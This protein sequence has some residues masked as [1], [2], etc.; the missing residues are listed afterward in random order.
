MT[1]EELQTYGLSNQP[2]K[3]LRPANDAELAIIK[4][5]IS[6]SDEA[7]KVLALP[8]NSDALA[9]TRF[10]GDNLRSKP[11]SMA[12]PRP[13]ANEVRDFGTAGFRGAG[14]FLTDTI[15][16]GANLVSPLFSD[17]Q[18]ES[19]GF[20]RLKEIQRE[21][22]AGYAP[23]EE[24]YP[25]ATTVGESLVPAML[26]GYKARELAAV[27]GL[28]GA[29]RPADS[30]VEQVIS[31]VT[32][33]ATSGI[34]AKAIAPRLKVLPE[35]KTLMDEGI[36]LTPGQ[37]S[38][39]KV[40]KGTE[41]LMTSL[42]GVGPRVEKLYGDTIEQF[43]INRIN[44]ALKPIGKAISPDTEAGTEAFDE[45]FKTISNEYKKELNG[46]ILPFTKAN[47]S[48]VEKL[49]QKGILTVNGREKYWAVLEQALHN[50]R[51][52]KGTI[53]GEQYQEAL[54][55]IR[56]HKRNF[57]NSTN[58][59]DK[60]VLEQLGAAEKRLQQEALSNV[61]D[62]ASKL[63]GADK[64]YAKL[65]V[66]TDAGARTGGESG[67]FSPAQLSAAIKKSTSK[68]DLV[69]GKGYDQKVSDAAKKVMTQQA[70]SRTAERMG[71]HNALKGTSDVIQGF[72]GG[73]AVAA[74]GALPLISAYGLLGTGTTKPGQ[75][76]IK[77]YLFESG[78]LRNALSKIPA[79][80]QG[81]TETEGN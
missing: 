3:S 13:L 31:G 1:A 27:G 25:L 47:L 29:T 72:I 42:F 66:L 40:L 49:P 12:A 22:D 16:G 39:G 74:G 48:K 55:N 9:H 58:P 32:G 8:E 10:A 43:N 54:S 7:A 68:Q 65:Q 6:K 53:T 63:A 35:A 77:K 79:I 62:K 44:N 78:P 81:Q 19:L 36:T 50:I 17:E 64:A 11:P 20:N 15:R 21:S 59:D 18:K 75:K 14:K 41:G 60:Y 5:A 34:L 61:P 33:G 52:P 28:L 80:M 23:I 38:A 45:A 46:A 51:K 73:S 76:I 71:V 30:P 26:P 70:N 57:V 4:Q 56:A 2:K 69:R 67:M 37:M 24:A